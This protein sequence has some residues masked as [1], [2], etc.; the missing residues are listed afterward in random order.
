MKNNPLDDI[1][2]CRIEI[3]NPA[4]A[5]DTFDNILLIV[6][7]PGAEGEKKITGTFE[8][9]SA[10]EL[11]D[12]GF[13]EKDSAYAAA[14]IAFSQDPSPDSVFVCVRKKEKGQEDAYE[15][16]EKTLDRADA[17]AAFYG[18]HLTDFRSTADRETAMQWAEEHE[19]LFGFEYL[20]DE[21]LPEKD[22]QWYRSF[23]MYAGNADGYDPET[24]PAGN[25]FLALAWMAKCF[26][27]DPGTETWHL[28]ELT[29]AVPSTLDAKDKQKLTSRKINTFLRYAGCNVTIGGF[30]LAGEWIDVIRFRDWLKAE[31]QA[32]V[33]GA[34]RANRKVPFTDAGIGLIE[35]K[36]EETLARGQ[37][38]GG[39][40][41]SEYDSDGNETPGYQVFVP[42]ATDL[43]ELERKTRKLTGCRYTARLS[44]AIHAVEIQGFLSF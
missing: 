39:I 18:I 6:K 24:L 4:S 12:Y 9:A 22:F 36:M 20:D 31:M 13:T 23:S 38:V 30:T 42:R 29:G 14:W 37:A 10:D 19:K 40:A 44:G 1:V 15:S 34:L 7:E 33:F 26:G 43:T 21:N 17:E 11:L 27:Y 2:K 41:P 3:S 16:I 25:R 32:S 28:K 8:T 35:G 5:D